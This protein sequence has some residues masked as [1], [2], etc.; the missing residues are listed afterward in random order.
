MLDGLLLDAA[1]MK[2]LLSKNGKARR[3]AH[4]HDASAGPDAVCLFI[5]L[6]FGQHFYLFHR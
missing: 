2:E 6:L 5:K 3:E 1:A 4:V